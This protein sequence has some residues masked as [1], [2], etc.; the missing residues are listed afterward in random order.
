M[1]WWDNF[2]LAWP[3][4][5]Q[6]YSD[7]FARMWRYYLMICAAFFRSGEGQLWQLV[8]SAQSGHSVYRSVR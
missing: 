8:L 3:E 1:A 5:S 4:L 2:Q 6:H 7:R